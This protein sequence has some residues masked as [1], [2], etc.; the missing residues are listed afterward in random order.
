MSSR[1]RVSGPVGLIT[2]AALIA[3]SSAA[4]ATAMTSS[5]VQTQPTINGVTLTSEPS[6]VGGGVLVPDC[7]G[8]SAEA[9]AYAISNEIDICGLLDGPGEV[10]TQDYRTGL[11]G[12]SG[13]QAYQSPG[14]N[15]HIEYG[16]SSTVGNMGVRALEVEWAG[17]ASGDYILDFSFM[18][19]AVYNSSTVGYT[20]V[21]LAEVALYGTA[22][23]VWG[24]TCYLH[25]P[26]S[27]IVVTN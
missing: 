2:A 3:V 22:T 26:V 1:A 5:V 14:A 24:L 25:G 16:F 23:T 11:C 21:G 19:S 18:N 27:S 9:A 12:S 4:P 10:S 17:S 20:G 7:A 8:L 6:L 15:V 13:I